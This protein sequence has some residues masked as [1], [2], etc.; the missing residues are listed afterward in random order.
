MADAVAAPSPADAV[1]AEGQSTRSADTSSAPAVAEAEPAKGS[2]VPPTG[3]VADGKW[4]YSLAIE[5]LLLIKI[6]MQLPS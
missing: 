2:D 3:E 6:S 1:N 5:G 4:H